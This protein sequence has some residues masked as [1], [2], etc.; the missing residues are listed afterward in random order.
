MHATVCIDNEMPNALRCT[1]IHYKGTRDLNL[2]E[3]T[4]FI[5]RDL[6]TYLKKSETLEPSFSVALVQNHGVSQIR[7]SVTVLYQKSIQSLKS[8]IDNILW[9]Y[10]QQIFLQDGGKLKALP[11]RFQFLV[12]ITGRDEDELNVTAAVESEGL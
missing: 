5:E 2:K 9:S 4:L 7:V 3:L 12:N 11:P 6:Y 1:G 8:H 10:N